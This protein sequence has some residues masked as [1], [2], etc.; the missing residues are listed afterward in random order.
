MR[1]KILAA[2][3]LE[4]SNLQLPSWNFDEDLDC[5]AREIECPHVYSAIGRPQQ[6]QSLT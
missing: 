2:F 4:V 6:Y 3:T 1:E 5:L